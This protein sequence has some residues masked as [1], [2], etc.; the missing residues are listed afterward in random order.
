MSKPTAFM[1]SFRQEGARLDWVFTKDLPICQNHYSPA[2][3]PFTELE[4]RN[5]PVADHNA[6]LLE[7]TVNGD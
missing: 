7:I 5:C 6:L 3:V 4:Y 2:V 1:K